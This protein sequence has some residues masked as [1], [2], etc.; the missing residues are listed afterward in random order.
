M[1]HIFLALYLDSNRVEK[2]YCPDGDE[3]RERIANGRTF[4]KVSISLTPLIAF[5]IELSSVLLT[6]SEVDLLQARKR[7]FKNAKRSGRKDGEGG[8]PWCTL[9]DFYSGSRQIHIYNG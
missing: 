6:C 3:K 8:A 1:G 2:G 4:E 5:L 7:A 9:A